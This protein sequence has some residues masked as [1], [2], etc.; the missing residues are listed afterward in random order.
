MKNVLRTLVIILVT[1]SILSARMQF[2]EKLFIPWGESENELRHQVAPGL[3]NGPSSFQVD[4][5]EILI[6]DN[7]NNKLKIFSKNEYRSQIEL[8]DPFILDFYRSGKD[9][10]FMR[11]DEVYT[12]KNGAKE[13]VA[14]LDDDKKMFMGLR[15]NK[16]E[17]SVLAPIGQISLRKNFLAKENE[18][19]VEVYRMLPSS[20]IFEL[21]EH[22]YSYNIPEIGSV[23]YIGTR[24]DGSHY[25]YAESIIQH[26]PL[27]VQRYI[28]LV[29]KKGE[30]LAKL[31]L[32][33]QKYTYIFK[34]FTVGDTGELYHMHSAKDGIH[35]ICWDYEQ[36]HEFLTVYPD[37]FS[38]EYHF[39]DFL[40]AE[41]ELAE[42]ASLK[43]SAVSSVARNAALETADEYV[44][45]IW[46][47]TAAN[48]GV[49]DIVTTPEWIQIGQNQKVP[50][51]WGGWNSVAA[52]DVGIAAGK[53]AGDRNTSAG[54]DW[55]GCVGADCSG[56]VCIC[57]E[58]TSRYTTSSFHQVT[59]ELSSFNDLLP[60][61]ATND[62]GSH[63]RLVVDWTNQG[64]LI[65]IE[66]TGSGWAA[67]YYTW[68]I[69]DLS[70]YKPI[71]YNKIASSLAP[72]PT[73]SSV[74]AKDDS[75]TLMWE[76]LENVDFTGYAVFKKTKS[77]VN[78]SQVTTVPKGT[79]GVRIPQS[80]GIHYDYYV[81][82]YTDSDPGNY[83]VSDTYACKNDETFKVLLVDGFDRMGSY[84]SPT[85]EFLS[86][87][88]D[89]LDN[90]GVSYDACT[91][92]AVIY[93]FVD[94]D[95]YDLVWW[96]LGDESTADQTFN[97]SEQTHVKTY[98]KQGGQLF[99]S[100]SELA[101]DLDSKGSTSDKAFIHDYLKCSF[102]VD[103]ADSYTVAGHV[104]RLFEGLDFQFSSDGSQAGTYPEDYPDAFNVSGGSQVVLKYDN[105]LNAAVAYR[106]IFSGGSQEGAVVTMGFPFEVITSASHRKQVA[107]KILIYMGYEQ[108]SAIDEFVPTKAFLK[109]NYP[110]PF[111]PKTTLVY[112][113]SE[114]SNVKIKI[115]N[116]RGELV[117]TIHE[118]KHN[119]GEH[120]VIFD[121]T[122]LP[123]G[124]YVYGLEVNESVVE[125]RKLLLNK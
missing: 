6:L 117:K 65:Q 8:I 25:L 90:W 108:N 94:L 53:L 97:S 40:E 52:F 3:H 96:I 10:Y 78:F 17:L 18:S 22:K 49:T 11:Q 64:K 119:A 35:I 32:P 28:I 93:S 4:G 75:V 118:G 48:I 100:G 20:L 60:A 38:E 43:K 86:N 30:A 106:G 23:D 101:W 54:V 36:D 105:D 27:K 83:N 13:Q 121:G 115:F 15:S 19:D 21:D 79:F 70:A 74:V 109:Q 110:N 14:N 103:D 125:A 16:H 56:F 116:I 73:L 62:A 39:N 42:Q 44:T 58:T 37:S 29:D 85:H 1:M 88:A 5:E 71:R 24:P 112:E 120:H 59:T 113:L 91:N 124:M 82:A 12:L 66:E 67:R 80:E 55:S 69:S 41:P 68:N 87:T 114:A 102:A 72:S 63:I 98:L 123:S 34:E 46:T 76:A 31:E 26:S 104:G 95:D 9:I 51:K 47:A 107:E 77:A 92:E 122:N 111:N 61:D 57:W 45:H 84:G 89:A 33:R 99:V 2:S 81:G 50:Y 7:E